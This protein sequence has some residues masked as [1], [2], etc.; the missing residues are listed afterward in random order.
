MEL[1]LP[2]D[3]MRANWP[4][5]ANTNSPA[6]HKLN[7]TAPYD[8]SL[9]GQIEA[10]EEVHV[11]EALVSAY[12][13]FRAKDRWLPLHQRISILRK[14]ATLV[15]A[16]ADSLALESAR[17]GG[18]PL[19]D[20]QVEVARVLECLELACE[21][22]AQH[23]GARVPMGASE[24]T[25]ERLAVTQK[26]PIG[27]VVAV[28]AFN[29]PLNLIAHQVFSAV[30]AG[31]PVIVKPAEDT[32]LACLRLVH[33]LHEAGL[34]PAWCQCLMTRTNSV[35]NRLVTDARVAFLSFIGSA[36]V[37]WKLRSQLPPGTRCALEHGGLAPVVMAV[38]ANQAAAC[39]ALTAGGFYHAGQVCV[40][41]Q[42]VFAPRAWAREFGQQLAHSAQA[43]QV[44]DPT[45][46]TTEVGPLIRPAEVER[47]HDWVQEAIQGGAE[48]LCGGESLITPGDSSGVA[49]S[50]APTVLYN[51]PGD[52]RVSQQEI[53]GPVVAIYPYDELEDACHQ[54]NGV[55]FAFQAAVFT[56]SLDTA[57]RVFKW[58]DASAV[59][60]NDHTAFRDD[61]MPFAGLRRSGLGV[62]GIPHSIDEMQIEKMLVINSPQ[63]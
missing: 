6:T 43:L 14:A 39:S 55:A 51:P 21:H 41:V 13:L 33:I 15:S 16:H 45:L 28:S 62:G 40:S 30:A 2:F 35:A 5:L 8:G 11:D 1:A 48:L 7:V 47:V 12:A 31:A 32:P 54:A 9:I 20:S 22:I 38:D 61:G 10:A 49:R 19:R 60:V 29:H 53:F 26:E 34:P 25:A 52:A 44:G 27:V 57:L 3:P 37:G 23:T 63:L 56:D 18:K 4:L 58:I 46:D 17:E 42:R 36:A 50:Y 59:M 24:R